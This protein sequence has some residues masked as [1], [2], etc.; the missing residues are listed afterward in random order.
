MIEP[1][2]PN[3]L[4]DW[5]GL[6]AFDRI[7]ISHIE[8][9]V[10]ATLASCEHALSELEG[11]P[12]ATWSALM[13]PLERLEDDLSRVWGIVRHLHAVRN[14]PDL[15]TVY[16]R[17]QGDVVAFS[18]RLGQS[19]PLFKAFRTLRDSA[20]WARYDEAQRRI[21]ESYIREAELEGVGLEGEARER[22][23]ALTQRYAEL[24]TRFSN[25]VLDATKDFTLTLTS[26]DDVEGLPASLLD[27]ALDTAR[28]AGHPDATPE[29][30]PWVI[31]LDSPSFF[32]FLQ[33]STRRDLRERVYRAF[34]TR[35][36]AGG[37]DNTPLIDE[38]LDL[39]R[40]KALLLGFQTFAEVS[41]SRKMAPD[42]ETIESLLDELR[43]AAHT[44]AVRDLEE[45]RD[46]ARS[47]GA[48]EA[49]D[50]RHWDIPFWAERLR[51]ARYDL[52]DEELRPY[53]ALPR[54]LDGLFPL[55]ERLFDIRVVPADG[56]ASV[57]HEDVRLFRVYDRDG[58]PLAVFYLDPYSRPAEKRG[59]AWMDMLVG[60]SAVMAPPGA[61]VRLPIAYLMCNQTR[62][63]GGKPSLMTFSEVETLFHEF[64]HALQHM[65]TTVDYGP[66][67]GISNVEWDA[68]EL[69]SQFMENWCYHKPTL[70]GLAEHYETGQPLPDETVERIRKARTFRAGTDTLRQVLFGLVDLELHHRFNPAG[71]EKPVDI[72]TRLS[73]QTLVLPP[74]PEDR[75]LC[76]FTHIFSGGYAAGYYSYKWAEVLSADAFA[77][78]DEAGLDDEATV[79]RLGR[80]FR[81]T[82]LA[83]GG[84]RHPMDVFK[85]FRGREPSTE[86]LLRYSGLKG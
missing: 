41:L 51:E 61:A 27:L 72:Y 8:P 60:R 3:P 1:H 12:P 67:A 52:H 81:E 22:F 45:L 56:E 24:S 36:S 42:V 6:P 29:S 58:S 13:E 21:L 48:A 11:T 23:N 76:A 65:L 50:L 57:W 18:T 26:R 19:R 33:H 80:C 84:S 34:I 79:R 62:P 66:A 74:L 31:T 5:D 68:V 77:A 55:A 64:G 4:L 9:A 10:R 37:L 7:E 35:A 2:T 73:E 71:P 25:N 17:L 15:R 54:V 69:A 86:A 30:G 82:V 16:D 75:F 78:F 70:L 59:G 63:V 14:S 39:R 40:E 46:L 38:I 49:D 32:P 85:A 47:A 53:F 43:Q 44:A 28:S 20:E 83:L